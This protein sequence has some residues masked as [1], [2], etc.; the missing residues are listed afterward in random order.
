M[1]QTLL[2][3]YFEKE[4]RGNEGGKYF[5]TWMVK[6]SSAAETPNYYFPL[7]NSTLS[8]RKVR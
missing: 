5:S 4:M 7:F 8:D 3:D 1:H 2:C 6:S